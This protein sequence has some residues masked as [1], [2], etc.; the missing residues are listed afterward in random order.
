LSVETHGQLIFFLVQWQIDVLR[1]IRRRKEGW[2]WILFKI[3][4]NYCLKW[5]P[6]VCRSAFHYS[7]I[8][9]LFIWW[10]NIGMVRR[11]FH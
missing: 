2:G 3:G 1:G 11:C 9:A 10:I 7:L 6:N 8:L 4:L 5:L